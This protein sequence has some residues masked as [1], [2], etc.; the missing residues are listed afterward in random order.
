M[1]SEHFRQCRTVPTQLFTGVVLTLNRLYLLIWLAVANQSYGQNVTFDPSLDMSNQDLREV[2]ELF[3]NYV[4]T[5]TDIGGFNPFWNAADQ[6][7]FEQYDFLEYEFTPS[8]YMG[9]PINVLNVEAQDDYYTIKAEFATVHG[10]GS[11]NVLAVVNFGVRKEH[12][13]YRLF[14]MLEVNREEW[15]C[16][17]VDYIDFYYPPYHQFDSNKAE[18]LH[19]FVEDL[20]RNFGVEPQPFEYYL[21]DDFD[22]IQSLRGFDYY[23]G[24]GAVEGPRGKSLDD[25]VYCGGLGEYYVHEVV[26]V[27]IDEH[28]PNK[29]FWITEGLA[30]YLGGSR[31]KSLDWHIR[32]TNTFL[33]EHPEIDLNNMLELSNLDAHTSYHYVLGGLVV[34]RV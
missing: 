20:C 30:T 10:D 2:L 27:Q 5:K 22:E 28:F 3:E 26:H 4:S 29:H 17:S 6:R 21:A 12:G 8:L 33:N 24:M 25:K 9:F 18:Q 19:S 7:Q 1:I 34:Q 23:L 15:T 14:N 13:Q 16:T 32:R 11:P 31:G